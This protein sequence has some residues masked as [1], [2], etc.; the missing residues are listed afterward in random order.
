MTLPDIIGAFAALAVFLVQA[1]IAYL[2]LQTRLEVANLKVYL[3][4]NFVS[5]TDFDR[6]K[7]DVVRSTNGK[8]KGDV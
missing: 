5:R 6:Y 3:Y 4:Q 7:D 2:I 1:L 8:T